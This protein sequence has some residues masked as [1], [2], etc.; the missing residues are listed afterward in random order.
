MKKKNKLLALFVVAVLCVTMIVPVSAANTIYLPGNSNITIVTGIASA[1]IIQPRYQSIYSQTVNGS[2]SYNAQFA[3]AEGNGPD[4]RF[5]INNTGST[6]IYVSMYVNGT[7]VEGGDY[8]VPAGSTRYTIVNSEDG[9][10][11]DTFEFR[12]TTNSPTGMNCTMTAVQGAN[13]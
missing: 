2:T 12:L 5:T 11:S 8:I 7:Y 3:C 1:P 6:D 13:V 4:M 10:L 9:G